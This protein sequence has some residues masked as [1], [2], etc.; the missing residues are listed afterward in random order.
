MRGK[1]IKASRSLAGV[2][3]RIY[4]PEGLQLER[5]HSLFAKIAV[6]MMVTSVNIMKLLI[7]ARYSATYFT[8]IILLFNLYNNPMRHFF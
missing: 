6:M 2:H 1:G 7:C 8:R 4:H 5:R 3:S